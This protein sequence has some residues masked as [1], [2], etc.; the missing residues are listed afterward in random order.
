MDDP[1]QRDTVACA[2]CHGK[3]AG[4][5]PSFKTIHYNGYDP[6]I[7]A[8]DGTRYADDG[9]GIGVF[10]VSIDSATIDANN[11]IDLK[12]SATGDKGSLHA[13]AIKPT[14]LIGLYG[15]D[16]KDFIVGPHLS[17]VDSSRNLEHVWG[18]TNP[19][20]TDVSASGGQWEVK[21]DLSAWKDMITA[22]QIK[23]AEI[24]VLP[25]ITA[26]DSTQTGLYGSQILG[27]NAPSKTFNLANNAFE[28]YYPDLVNVFKT[29]N[30]NTNGSMDGCNTCHDQLATTFHSGIRGGNIKV[31]RMC[32]EVS[33]GASHLELQSR[34]IDSYVH[35]IHSFQG[36]D[37][38]NINPDDEV[39]VTEYS[40]H[41]S[42]YFP[43]FTV[44]DCE[45]CH[46]NSTNVYDSGRHAYDVPMQGKSMPGVLSGSATVSF[47]GHTLGDVPVAVTGPAVRAC[48]ACH[49][50]QAINTNDPGR[51]ALQRTHWET[52]GYYIET[53]SDVLR[54]LWNAVVAKIMPLFT[55]TT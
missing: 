49:R 40:D 43:R 35:A 8:L 44:Q 45:A 38:K 4:I 19:R 5:G 3:S 53:T 42:F 37:T 27:L 22:G 33:S 17:T 34:S 39:E 13:T 15:Y 30:A 51:L 41:V 24:A 12:F 47:T 32:H 25:Q 23:R 7:Y 29:A 6:K 31:C 36:L 2:T 14:V 21:V 55:A 52:F 18:D 50:A 9:T 1:A 10:K 26:G 28:T 11:V 16:T 46:V 20:F 48:G 54:D